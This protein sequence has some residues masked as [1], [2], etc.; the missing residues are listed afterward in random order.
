MTKSQLVT[1][2]A[3]L[4]N[5]LTLIHNALKHSGISVY[6]DYSKGECMLMFGN[7]P[8]NELLALVNQQEVKKQP[9]LPGGAPTVVPVEDNKVLATMRWLMK[10]VGFQSTATDEFLTEFE[11]YTNKEKNWLAVYPKK[12]LQES[13]KF[14]KE[15]NQARHARQVQGN[16]W[17]NY[18]M[19]VNVPAK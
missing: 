18:G 2:N 4:N 11:V 12:G 14:V 3:R 13:G 5:E 15:L 7:K 19:W 10:Y 1:E 16:Y 6:G 8:A 17:K 9:K